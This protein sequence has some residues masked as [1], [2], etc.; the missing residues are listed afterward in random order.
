LVA[1][2]MMAQSLDQT[3]TLPPRLDRSAAASLAPV[4]A[5]AIRDGA[6]VLDGRAVERIGQAGMQLLLSARATARAAGAVLSIE[7]SLA[8]HDAA[9]LA[10]LDQL[11]FAEPT[12]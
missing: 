12:A 10:G 7:P 1:L 3:V 5:T 2:L 8:M 4:I 6:V 9:C 11:L